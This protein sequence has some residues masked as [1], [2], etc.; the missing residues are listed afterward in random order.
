RRDEEPFPP[1]RLPAFP[2]VTTGSSLTAFHAPHP[3]HRP[4]HLGCSCPHSAQ[5]YTD[6]ARAILDRLL[7][8][9]EVVEPG[10]LPA[11]PELDVAG[12][13]VAVLGQHDLRDPAFAFVFLVVILGP[14]DEDH[15]IS[16]L[17]DGT[18]VAQVGQNR[19]AL[20]ATL[21][22]GAGELRQR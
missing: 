12:R 14:V 3:S 22:G 16:I 13:A 15:D 5:R 19:L 7:S 11:E 21:L 8:G 20:A 10:E 4:T 1:S 2:P 18:R 17:L 6:R 9:A